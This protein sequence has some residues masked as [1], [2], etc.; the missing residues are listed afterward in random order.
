MTTTKL[1]KTFA[2]KLPSNI[3]VTILSCFYTFV[4]E[5]GYRQHVFID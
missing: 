5:D 3:D 4:K 2:L 1:T